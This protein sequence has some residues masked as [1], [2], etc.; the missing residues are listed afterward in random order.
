MKTASVFKKYF[1]MLRSIKRI[2][3]TLYGIFI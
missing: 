2:Q 3:F 1:M